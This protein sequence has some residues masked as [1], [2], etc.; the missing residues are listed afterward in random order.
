MGKQQSECGIFL[1]SENSKVLQFLS[2]MGDTTKM[3]GL[4][5]CFKCEHKIGRFNYCGHQCS[6]KQWICPSFKIIKSKVDIHRLFEIKN[7][8]HQSNESRNNDEIDD[9]EQKENESVEKDD[10]AD[11]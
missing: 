9:E 3:E 11:C 6:C 10:A 1:D 2:A 4:L 5:S 7:D 8:Q